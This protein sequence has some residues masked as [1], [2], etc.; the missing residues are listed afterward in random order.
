MPRWAPRPMPLPT[1]ERASVLRPAR[2][3]DFAIAAATADLPTPPLPETTMNRLS[4]MGRR[5]ERAG[6]HAIIWAAPDRLQ[7][8]ATKWVNDGRARCRCN[9]RAVPGPGRGSEGAAA[10][11]GGRIRAEEVRRTGRNGLPGLRPDRERHLGRRRRVP[12]PPNPPQP[13]RLSGLAAG[14]LRYAACPPAWRLER[15][16]CSGPG[17][18]EDTP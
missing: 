7:E 11:S 10:S 16:F 17:G 13:R 12:R 14:S 4:N 3:A 8:D 6:P 18:P 15:V 5:L 2:A 9:D 1:I